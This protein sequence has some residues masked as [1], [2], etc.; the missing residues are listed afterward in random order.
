MRELSRI[1][2]L[3]LIVA[4]FLCGEAMA[5]EEANCSV[6]SK[7]GDLELRR[8]D[9]HLAI[10]LRHAK[11][12]GLK[13]SGEPVFARHNPPFTPWFLRRNEIPIPVERS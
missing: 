3:A 11:E 8:D 5:V 1:V 7:K 6:I 2:S 9:T 4:T 13:Q 10:L 12:L